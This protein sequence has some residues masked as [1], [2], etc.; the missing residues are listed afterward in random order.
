MRLERNDIATEPGNGRRLLWSSG[1]MHHVEVSG[2]WRWEFC[3]CPI[4]ITLT[5]LNPVRRAA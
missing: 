3:E 2:Y 1:V 4:E 5:I